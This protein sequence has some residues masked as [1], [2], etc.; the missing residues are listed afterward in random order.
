MT[1]PE[2]LTQTLSFFFFGNKKKKQ[3]YV[4]QA[5]AL[6]KPRTLSEP[7]QGA[8]VSASLCTS[9]PNCRPLYHTFSLCE[10]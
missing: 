5:L 3:N 9:A 1:K 10:I 4:S 6:D 2:Q 7:Y 8:I